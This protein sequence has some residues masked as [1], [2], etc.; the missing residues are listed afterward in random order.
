MAAVTAAEYSHCPQLVQ[1]IDALGGTRPPGLST[2]SGSHVFR[3]DRSQEN[4]MELPGLTCHMA[5]NG[6][7]TFIMSLS[8]TVDPSAS[9]FMLLA[10]LRSPTGSNHKFL[11]YTNNGDGRIGVLLCGADDCARLL[12]DSPAP[13]GVWLTLAVRYVRQ[14]SRV[15]VLIDGELASVVDT[16]NLKSDVRS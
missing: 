6:G 1:A 15:E 16:T 9:S 7:F 14:A 2:D 12:S 8:F 10:C 3:F 5:S 13:G 11:L 4:Y